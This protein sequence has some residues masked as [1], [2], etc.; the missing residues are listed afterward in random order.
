MNKEALND[1]AESIDESI[2][3]MRYALNRIKDCGLVDSEQRM[4]E[5]HLR[6]SRRLLDMAYDL[7]DFA[8]DEGDRP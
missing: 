8:D 5:D 2:E 6:K 4:I 3:A 7:V 1:V